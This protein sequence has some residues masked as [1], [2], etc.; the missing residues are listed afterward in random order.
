[1][2]PNAALAVAWLVEQAQ[3]VS[4][5]YGFNRRCACAG[6]RCGD[7]AHRLAGDAAD[8]LEAVR[9]SRL[10]ERSQPEP[11]PEG[12]EDGG[13]EGSEERPISRR[14]PKRR[15]SDPRRFDGAR[16]GRPG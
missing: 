14:G 4:G 16:G 7:S 2:W 12:G 15:A 3:W 6:K 8:V 9:E 5:D 10:A 1:M 13:P 11:E